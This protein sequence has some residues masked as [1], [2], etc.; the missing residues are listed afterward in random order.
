MIKSQ[1]TTDIFLK[2]FNVVPV[3]KMQISLVVNI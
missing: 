1:K 3:K 2:D